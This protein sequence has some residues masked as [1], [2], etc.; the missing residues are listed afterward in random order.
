[1]IAS[2][3]NLEVTSV[4]QESQETSLIKLTHVLKL[5]EY[6]NSSNKENK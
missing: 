1:M 3:N 6:R 4:V 2:A 5:K